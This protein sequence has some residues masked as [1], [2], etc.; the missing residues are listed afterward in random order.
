[1]NPL[2]P[3]YQW[4]IRDWWEPTTR[5]TPTL[6]T[7]NVTAS[8]STPQTAE[9]ADTNCSGTGSSHREVEHSLVAVINPVPEQ[10]SA[11]EL[12]AENRVLRRQLAGYR[13]RC[14]TLTSMMRVE[15]GWTPEQIGSELSD[16]L[17]VTARAEP[18]LL[19]AQA[20]DGLPGAPVVE[21]AAPG[22]PVTAPE[23]LGDPGVGHG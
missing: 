10:V 8:D 11:D 17:A 1:M 22:V 4:W 3:I 14:A 18:T 12:Q 21:W 19:A 5:P 9:L 15:D 7:K 2:T 23:G 6:F 16:L 13:T 20:D